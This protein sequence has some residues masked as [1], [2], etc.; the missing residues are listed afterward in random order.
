MMSFELTAGD[1][2]VLVTLDGL[3]SLDAWDEVLRKIAVALPGDASP[4][5]V[6]DMR[7]VLGY[8]G[9]PERTAVGS[10]MASRLDC[11]RKVAIVVQARKIT[12]VV[13]DEARRNGLELRLFPDYDDATAW[14]TS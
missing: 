2:F 5:L 12:N 14:A 13:R 6:I 7:S 3:V 9:I 10:M 4:C 11:M 8:L 1:G